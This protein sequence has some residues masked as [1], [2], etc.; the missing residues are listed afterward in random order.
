MVIRREGSFADGKLDPDLALGTAGGAGESEGPDSGRVVRVGKVPERDPEGSDQGFDGL[1]GLGV[2][3]LERE[4]GVV[5]G[6]GEGE[7]EPLIPDGAGRPGVVGL[8]GEAT[9]RIDPED[10]VGLEVAAVAP[11]D[12][13][14]VLGGDDREVE[15]EGLR[16]RK[17]RG[18][19]VW[20]WC[21]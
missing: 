1:G 3:D 13:L 10:G 11:V 20:R 8:G 9:V 12:V 14:E 21:W 16:R 4:E 15:I 2:E 19:H 18:R 17:A 6:G 7:G 5:E